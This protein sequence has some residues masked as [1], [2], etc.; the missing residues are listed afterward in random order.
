M[1]AECNQADY[2]LVV[3]ECMQKAQALVSAHNEIIELKR[4]KKEN[5]VLHDTIAELVKENE[6]L[7]AANEELR[8]L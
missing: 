4:F 3:E 2:Q 5:E 7:T 8:K 1:V 6:D